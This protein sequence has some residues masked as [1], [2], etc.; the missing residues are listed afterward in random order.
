MY[1]FPIITLYFSR[2]CRSG[3]VSPR[4][5][6]NQ[7]L[8]IIVIIIITTTTVQYTRYASSAAN[9]SLFA[10]V[11][12]GSD[13]RCIIVYLDQV[14]N[15]IYVLFDVGTSFYLPVPAIVI[16]GEDLYIQSRSAHSVEYFIVS[17]ANERLK[18][19]MKTMVRMRIYRVVTKADSTE[20][21]PCDLYVFELNPGVKWSGMTS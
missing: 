5:Q 2:Y 21:S 8:R 18:L 20:S 11:L 12:H 17:N 4:T 9:R 6:L 14:H 7:T 3:V 16:L 13:E 15:I 19:V 1:C 10:S